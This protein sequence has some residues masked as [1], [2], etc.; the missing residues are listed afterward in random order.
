M[1][2][3]KLKNNYG[4]ILI[5]FLKETKMCVLNGRIN[6]EKDNFT[7]VSNRGKSVVDYMLTP[8]DCY[9][10]IVDFNVHMVSDILL[11][12]DLYNVGP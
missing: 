6:P 3:T 5:D 12:H 1:L 4:D 2:L 11:E 7:C 8:R 9:G 10:N